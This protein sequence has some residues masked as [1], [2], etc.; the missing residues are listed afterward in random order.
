M[1]VREG[2]DLL[3]AVA[4]RILVAYLEKNGAGHVGLLDG[5][6]EG[7]LTGVDLTYLPQSGGSTSVKVK[8][9]PY[10]GSN[11]GAIADRSFVFY[12]PASD[13]YAFEAISDHRTR[14][15]GW[16]LRSTA[17]EL[18]YYRLAIAQPEAEIAALL[19]EPD[20]V[21]FGE[22]DVGVDSL[23]ILPMNEVRVWFAS[24][25]ERYA[26]RPV[27]VGDH[28]TWVRLI[29]ARDIAKGVP[30]VHAVGPVFHSLQARFGAA[31][32]SG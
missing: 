32:A 25:S 22:L 16:T 11:A 5:T 15:P 24:N 3:H 7:R 13:A 21:F 6:R 9:D 2:A 29:P 8:A 19:S 14:E 12:R 27:A 17:D 28:A 23:D 4:E 1:S 20:A 30:G 18:F 31:S 26:P 10:A